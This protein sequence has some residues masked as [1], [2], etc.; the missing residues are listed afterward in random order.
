VP[1]SRR[2]SRERKVADCTMLPVD[3]VINGDSLQIL[4]QIPDNTVDMSFADPPFNLDKKYG[5]YKDQ[6]AVEDYP[7][8]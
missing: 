3:Q 8:W 1:L 7:A 2:A 4:A 6:R 5:T